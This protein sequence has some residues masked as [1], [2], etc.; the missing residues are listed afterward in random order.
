MLSSL[1]TILIISFSSFLSIVSFA[2]FIPSTSPETEKACQRI[3]YNSTNQ[4]ILAD[5]ILSPPVEKEIAQY[6]IEDFNLSVYGNRF[7]KQDL[8]QKWASQSAN[9]IVATKV[10]Y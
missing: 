8:F 2:Q 3:Y 4:L 6:S 7:N 10:Q 1:S 5:S 9:N